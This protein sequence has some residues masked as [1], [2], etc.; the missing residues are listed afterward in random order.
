VNYPLFPPEF[1]TIE[2]LL[3]GRVR[4]IITGTPGTS[5]WLDRASNLVDWEAVT[6]L[7]NPAGTLEFMDSSDN[8]PDGRFYRLRQ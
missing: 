2:R 7:L 5:L 6:N 4:L 3:D 1:L 8:H